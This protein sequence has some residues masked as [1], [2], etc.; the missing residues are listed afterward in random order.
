MATNWMLSRRRTS[1]DGVA[2]Q[3]VDLFVHGIGSR[4]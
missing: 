2:D 3:V 4:A 1:L